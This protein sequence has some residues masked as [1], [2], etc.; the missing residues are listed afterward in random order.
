MKNYGLEWT[1]KLVEYA[2]KCSV[3]QLQN[4]RFDKAEM[5]GQDWDARGQQYTHQFRLQDLCRPN[6]GQS[7]NVIQNTFWCFVSDVSL[8]VSKRHCCMDA[9]IILVWRGV[10]VGIV[11]K[12][13][14]LTVGLICRLLFTFTFTFKSFSRRSYPERLTNWCI[15]LMTLWHHTPAELS[16]PRSKIIDQMLILSPGTG[17]EKYN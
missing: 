13:W 6:E 10:I 2:P 4:W 8:H 5:S 14:T 11:T 9:G 3:V 17:V 1:W 16:V 7:P 12:V 15:H